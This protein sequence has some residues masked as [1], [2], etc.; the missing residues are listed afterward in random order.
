MKDITKAK[1]GALAW[2]GSR[3]ISGIAWGSAIA[4][5]DN[6]WS[7]GLLGIYGLLWLTDRVMRQWIPEPPSTSE[8]IAATLNGAPLDE[9]ETEELAGVL[10]R[11]YERRKAPKGPAGPAN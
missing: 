1:I 3:G 9:A 8:Q 4:N 6:W 7:R 5:V 10:K 2:A 11:A